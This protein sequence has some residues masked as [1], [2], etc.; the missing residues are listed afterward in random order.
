MTEENPKRFWTYI[1][2]LKK[3]DPAVADL[4][5][6]GSVIIDGGSKTEILNEHFCG[7]FT[8]KDL[9]SIPNVWNDPKPKISPINISINGGMTQLTSLK[10]FKACGPDAIPP[11]FLK[12]YETEIAP[13]L[14]N[15]YQD[16]INTGTL[17]GWWKNANVC[18]VFKK[19][20]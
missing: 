13:I 6:N 4:K 1:R 5:I 7:V 15:I 18:G 8:K 2:Q 16:S 20:K 9:T 17:P 14:T 19:E 10:R 11:W 12:E 3:D